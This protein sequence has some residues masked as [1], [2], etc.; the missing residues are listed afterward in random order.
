MGK[1]GQKNLTPEE[2]LAVIKEHLVA[3]LGV[4]ELCEKH[5]IKP[6]AYYS[7]QNQLFEN[8]AALERRKSAHNE[9]LRVKRLTEQLEALEQSAR[10]KDEVLAE[11]MCEHLKLKKNLIGGS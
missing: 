4:P 3:G 1:S 9:S 7:W 5:G 2:K 8:S 11:L 6:S 10:Q